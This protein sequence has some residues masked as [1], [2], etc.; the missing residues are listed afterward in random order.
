M[1]KLAILMFAILILG[2]G[3][4]PN[5]TAYNRP[6]TI[7][8]WHYDEFENYPMDPQLNGVAVSRPL[9]ADEEWT[10]YPEDRW[11]RTADVIKPMQ[12]DILADK[13]MPTG[14]Y[15]KQ[16][17][18]DEY[19][20]FAKPIKVKG[21]IIRFR[22]AGRRSGTVSEYQLTLTIKNHATLAAAKQAFIERVEVIYKHIN[23]ELDD[24]EPVLRQNI[25]NER[26]IYSET[27]FEG[28]W[29]PEPDPDF[30]Y[31]SF[32]NHHWNTPLGW[33]VE[34]TISGSIHIWREVLT[35]NGYRWGDP[36]VIRVILVPYV[37]P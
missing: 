32:E 15:R 12:A 29:Q 7:L 4:K 2:C 5:Q 1:K 21:N 34:Y 23:W 25:L 14:I 18:A 31:H 17:F 26:F 20:C 11:I 10:R 37:Y 3:S 28:R 16:P 36:F 27:P 24:M 35:E 30:M 19:A 8:A 22:I 9:R 33:D 6:N 13:G